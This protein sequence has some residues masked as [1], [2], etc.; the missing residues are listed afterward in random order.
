M[1]DKDILRGL[2]QRYRDI[3]AMPVQ[4]ERRDLWRR[5]NSLKETRPLIYV[6]EGTAWN[7]IPE[8]TGLTCADPLFQ[9]HERF[10]RAMLFQETIGD[11][12]IFEPYVVVQASYVLPGNGVWGLTTHVE[13]SDSD[14]GGRNFYHNAPIKDHADAGRMTVPVHRIDER[15]T[16]DDLERI[17]DAIGDIIPVVLSRAPVWRHWNADISTE[18]TKLRGMEA[19]MMDMYDDPAWLH[20]V[21][22]FMRDG[23]LKAQD[24][25]ERAG[26]WHLYDNNNQAM[27]YAEGL[28]DPSANAQSVP[29]AK[30]WAHV[31]AQELTLISPAMHDEF[32]LRY[33][34]PI[35]EKFGL[36]AYGCCEDL[37]QKIDILR[38]VK[39]LRRI[40]VAPRANVRVCAEA[41]GRDYVFSWRPNPAEMVCCG[42]DEAK[43]KRIVKKALADAKGCHID[44]TLK[45]IQTVERDPTRL[46]RW[47]NAVREVIA[48]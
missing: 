8:I 33:Q 3:S 19:L 46:A 4:Q 16:A 12:Y 20:G 22:G 21:L 41:I 13:Q 5:H 35:M 2:A 27:S 40:A 45:D 39:N 44:I 26:D 10:F 23:I 7:E 42:Y 36:V 18:L 30:L 31:A 6:R 14:E 9:R 48:A 15:R 37:T 28:P 47:V 17:S 38:T 1:S 43:V 34:L 29:R 24:E 32:M 11:D 25:A